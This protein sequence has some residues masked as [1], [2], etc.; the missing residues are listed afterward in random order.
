MMIFKALTNQAY[1]VIKKLLRFCNTI[2][3]KYYNSFK[4]FTKLLFN[5]M[6]WQKIIFLILIKNYILCLKK[7][8]NYH[9]TLEKLENKARV[10]LSCEA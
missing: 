10:I 5:K 8:I 9:Q 3:S 2:W 4:I 1:N 7:P 6:F